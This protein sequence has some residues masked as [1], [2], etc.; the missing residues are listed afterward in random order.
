[1]MTDFENFYC[2]VSK[3]H[4]SRIIKTHQTLNTPPHN[5]EKYLVIFLRYARNFSHAV[6]ATWNALPDHI[7]TVADPVKF[8]KLLK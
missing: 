8:R 7:R 4:K 1:M 6:P 5:L 3:F 2:H